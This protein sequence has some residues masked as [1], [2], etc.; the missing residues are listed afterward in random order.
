[1]SDLARQPQS[2]AETPVRPGRKTPITQVVLDKEA[3]RDLTDC[4][5]N[6][7]NLIEW[8][9]SLNRRPGLKELDGRLSEINVD[10]GA[11]KRNICFVE[12]GY[13][14][15]ILKKNDH[16]ELVAICWRP[17]QETPIHDHV[18]SDCAFLIL[19]GTSTETVYKLDEDGLPAEQLKRDYRPG[20]VCAAAEQDIHKVSNEKGGDLINLHVYTPPLSGFKIYKP[21][22]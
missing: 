4:C 20:E 17:K 5:K 2:F 9:D 18:G 1:M 11:L 10:I 8:L 22:S 7:K 6:T 3:L 14:R 21:K 19:E 15:N 12:N 16:Y 13:Q